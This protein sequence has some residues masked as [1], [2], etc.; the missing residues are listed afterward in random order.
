MVNDQIDEQ[1]K[2][3]NSDRSDGKDE[4]FFSCNKSTE[5]S[6]F[7]AED[8]DFE[9]NLKKF[10]KRLSNIS[11]TEPYRLIPNVESEWI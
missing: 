2:C 6:L 5:D 11:Q 1:L 4:T 3:F 10:E 7:D 9:S 8:D